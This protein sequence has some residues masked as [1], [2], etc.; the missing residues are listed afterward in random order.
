MIALQKN[1]IVTTEEFD[2]FE[3]AL[4][5]CP[6]GV[7]IL[8]H[9]FATGIYARELTIPAGYI[10]TGKIHKTEHINVVSM[11]DITV[12]SEE[13]GVRRIRAPYTFVAKPGTRRVGFAHA[14]T[15]WTTFHATTN[16]DLEE[17]EEELIVKHANP[18][19]SAENNLCLG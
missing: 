3:A 11:G 6:P 2:R 15:I 7:E 19:L 9:Y 14:D 12:W 18:F 10:L 13:H 8:N 1:N 17:I 5:K 4:A 16:T